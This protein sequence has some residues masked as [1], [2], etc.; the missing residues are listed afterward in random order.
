M[1]KIAKITNNTIVTLLRLLSYKSF[2]R[3]PLYHT[4][5]DKCKRFT[6]YLK[7]YLRK[8]EYEI[9]VKKVFRK[10]RIWYNIKVSAKRPRKSEIDEVYYEKTIAVLL[11]GVM[12]SALLL[13]GCEA[14]KGLENDDIKITQYKGIEID[15]VEKK[16]KEVTDDDVDSFIKSM[17][18]SHAEVTEITD[19]AV[20]DGDTVSINFVGKMNGE[21]FEGGSAEDYSLTIGSGVF[22]EG[23]EDSVIGHKAGETYDWNRKFPDDYGNAEMA[24]KRC[25]IYNY[26]K[27]YYKGRRAGA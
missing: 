12:A 6:G 5:A 27:C 23:F 20:E 1:I 8:G 4:L 18:E 10:Y 11:T 25:S 7:G 26:S 22:I 17:Q 9:S 13:S 21:E 19:R 14:S 24:G 3:I 15:E 2:S 16:A